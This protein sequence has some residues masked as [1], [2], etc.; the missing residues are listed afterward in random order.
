MQIPPGP[1][2]EFA[3]PSSSTSSCLP[4]EITSAPSALLDSHIGSKRVAYA[5]WFTRQDLQE[6]ISAPIHRF[7]DFD[8]WIVNRDCGYGNGYRP[9]QWPGLERRSLL[10]GLRDRRL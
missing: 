7:V 6:S 4:R 10:Y 8:F 2:I 1:P 5:T 9:G 3:S